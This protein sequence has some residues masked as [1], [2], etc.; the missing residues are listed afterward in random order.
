MRGTTAKVHLALDG[1]LEFACRPAERIAYAR[2][3]EDLDVL[4]RAFD[5]VKYRAFSE[6]PVLDIYVPTVSQ[7]SL[8]PEGH[9]VVSI[10]VSFAP[11]ELA[12]GW[13]DDHK[14]QLLETVLRV[15]ECYA[16]GIAQS[17][18]SSEVLSPADLKRRYG[19]TGGH[20][21]H[22]EHALD[23]LLIRPV[24]ECARYATPIS[25]LFLCGSGSHP[26]GGIT[27]APGALAAGVIA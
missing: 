20:I 24:P 2:T 14:Q 17:I 7:P 16:P 25:G 4:E 5:A 11:I 12:G 21:H 9:S 22:G 10:I 15:L 3:A 23:Q 8:A 18:V 13:T 19:L 27:C 6:V 1:P 26:G